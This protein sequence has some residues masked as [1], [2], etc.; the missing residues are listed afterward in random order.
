MALIGFS[1]RFNEFR[2]EFTKDTGIE[3]INDNIDL[4]ID[5]VAARFADQNNKLLTN[6]SV[7]LQELY[8]VLRKV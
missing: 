6:I 1:N 8:K 2:S 3:N 5:Y 4:Y 7:E